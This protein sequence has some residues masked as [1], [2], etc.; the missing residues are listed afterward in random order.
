MRIR[1]DFVTN[2]SSSSYTRARIKSTKLVDMM[3]GYGEKLEGELGYIPYAVN[4]AFDGDT[5]RFTWDDVFF[6]NGRPSSPDEVID[7]LLS[8]I[9][10]CAEDD[11]EVQE[12]ASELGCHREEMVDSLEEVDW[13]C[14]YKGFGEEDGESWSHEYHFDR[15][16]AEPV[17]PG[18]GR[19]RAARSPE[20]LAALNALREKYQGR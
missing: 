20:K 3:R 7:C 16:E 10:R 2:S 1:A 9:E 12:V 18:P 17:S 19:R 13:N 4:F 6:A 15:S 5:L 14:E 11:I 8:E